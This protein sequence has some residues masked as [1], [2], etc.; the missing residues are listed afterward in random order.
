MSKELLRLA[1]RAITSDDA[2]FRAEVLRRIDSA[3]AR[4]TGHPGGWKPWTDDDDDYL[5][6]NRHKRYK[7]IAAFLGRSVHSVKNR[8]YGMGLALKQSEWGRDEI[9]VLRTLGPKEAAKKIGRTVIACRTKALK[10]R[11]AGKWTR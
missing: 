6:L 4:T 10:L 11:K 2:D 5:V 7:H 3:V 8:A 9:E 1:A